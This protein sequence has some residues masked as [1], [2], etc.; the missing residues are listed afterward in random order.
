MNYQH[1]LFDV[2]DS[3]ATVT[4]NRPEVLNSLNTAMAKELQD[5]CRVIKEE[6]NIRAV[7]LTGTGKGFCAG[8]DLSGGPDVDV[9]AP[10]WVRDYLERDLNPVILEI[11][12]MDK[13][14]LSAVNGPAAGAG[15]NLA[16][17]TDLILVAEEAYF[18]EIFAKRGLCVDMGGMYL[19]P[20]L[21]GL[22]KAK[23]L[24]FFADRVYGPD[25]ERIGLANK[26]VPQALL[27]ETAMEWAKKLAAGA[28][29]AI[30]TTKV[31]MNMGMNMTLEEVLR[32]E[33]HAQ[34]LVAKTKDTMEGIT[35]FFEK[36]DPKFTGE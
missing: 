3:V 8:A 15:C 34:G 26:C 9:T 7:I 36:R 12:R 4:L 31:G 2:K 25:A 18:C 19:L 5:A 30:A 27:M 29:R 13:P 20:R 6:K 11:F 22:Q 10:F 17:S 16:L 35:A 32:Y 21:V 14:W 24:A 1:I 33:A 28:G 23:E